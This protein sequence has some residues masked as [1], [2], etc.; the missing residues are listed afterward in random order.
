MPPI[1]VLYGQPTPE[2]I[3]A[4]VAVFAAR[5]A[6]APPADTRPGL[7][8][9]TPRSAWAD[10]AAGLRRPLATRFTRPRSV[11]PPGAA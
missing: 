10:R 1:T 6:G 2:E 9:R 3:A 8:R 7:P 5:A 4:V 11:V